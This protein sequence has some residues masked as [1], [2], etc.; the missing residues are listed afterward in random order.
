MKQYL[1]LL[2]HVLDKGIRREDRTGVGTISVFGYQMRF[3]LEEGFPLLTTKKVFLRGII[4]EL[5]WFLKGETNIKYLVDNE[6]HIWDDWPYDSYRKA[7]PAEGSGI[8]LTQ[9]QFIHKLKEDS[10][11]ALKWGDLGPVYGQQWRNFNNQG[12]D[13]IKKVIETIQKKPHSRRILVIAYNPA[14]AD[15]MKLPPCHSLFQ[16]YVAEG[17]L[18]CQL[19]QRSCD[20]FLGVPFNLASYALLTMMVAQV[21]GLK[22]GEFV[23]TGGDTHI[24]LN[25]LDQVKEQLS[26]EPRPL[27]TMRI[28]PE[29]KDIFRFRYEDFQLEN[30]NPHPSIKA[31]IAV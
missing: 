16:F 30:Y 28:N 2:R 17:K 1:E 31:P 27:P 23:W 18:S 5:L 29:V 21:T 9:E 6:V 10:D 25:H 3:N 19:Y 15:L 13:Q 7:A 14:Q 11:F 12:I 26:R 24:Y 4:H 20:V 8:L 22:P